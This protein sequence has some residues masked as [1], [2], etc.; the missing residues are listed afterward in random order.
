H[1]I[2]GLFA[3]GM[4]SAGVFGVAVLASVVLAYMK[5]GDVAGT[6][7]AAHFDWVLATFWW[8]L[9]WLLLSALATW[10]FIGWITGVIAVLW[11]TYRL[12]RGW[13]AL[14]SRRS[15]TAVP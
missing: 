14:F 7:Y 2:Y 10:I 15:P 6:I 9:L 3:L 8:S 13:L 12:V 1:V 5:R 11:T 4:L